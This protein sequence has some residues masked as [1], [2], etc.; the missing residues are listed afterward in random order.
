MAEY[1]AQTTT[2]LQ[3]KLQPT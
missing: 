1:V 2:C 3:E